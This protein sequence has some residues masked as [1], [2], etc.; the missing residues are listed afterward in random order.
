MTTNQISARPQ[1]IGQLMERSWNSIKDQ[2]PITAGLSL[3]IW[4]AL[5]VSGHIPPLSWLLSAVVSAGW[6]ACLLK[7]RNKEEI[8]FN[9]FFWA[10]QNVNRFLNLALQSVLVWIVV[11][12]GLIFFVVPG[13]WAAIALSLSSILIVTRQVDGVEA[14]R[15]SR[16]L[17]RGNW[18]HTFLVVLT[19]LGLNLLGAL[20]FFVGLLVTMPLSLLMMVELSED[21]ERL[22]TAEPTSAATA[23]ASSVMDST[24]KNP[25]TFQVNP[26][27]DS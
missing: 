15:R 19:I 11:I 13:V 8:Q 6:L 25:S 14:L 12:A 2:L 20:C 24:P 16:S 5:G 23:G 9:D 17:V 18:W 4:A 26:Q 21:L 10:F 22:Q 3:V 7:I 1:S 27:S